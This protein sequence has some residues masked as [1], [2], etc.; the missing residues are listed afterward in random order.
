MLHHARS[1]YH[2]QYRRSDFSDRF[3]APENL[4]R[5]MSA[6]DRELAPRVGRGLAAD[7]DLV[8]ELH[9]FV[10]ELAACDRVPATL[11][12]AN[13]QFVARIA[14]PFVAAAVSERF[15]QQ[16][17]HDANRS[18]REL[19]HQRLHRV[20]TALEQPAESSQRHHSTLTSPY[21]LQH[22]FGSA[23]NYCA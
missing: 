21:M 4:A 22:P 1:Q 23:D 19:Y 6:I 5:V 17:V 9:R 8:D 16:T 20:D 18:G 11:E 14:E 2:A 7:A 10:T 13:N 12:D 15:H 3:L